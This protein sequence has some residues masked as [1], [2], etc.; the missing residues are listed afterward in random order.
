VSLILCL[1]AIPVNADSNQSNVN[2]FPAQK[3][4]PPV[5]FNPLT[6]SAAELSEY[7]FPARPSDPTELQ[8]WDNVMQYAKHYV[9]PVQYQSKMSWGLKQGGNNYYSDQA[10]YA[11]LSSDN[12]G[13]LT[14]N[15]VYGQWTQNQSSA[16]VGYWVGL[17]GMDNG[18]L[19]QAGGASDL[20]Q[21]VVIQAKLSSNYAFFVEDWPKL[22]IYEATP[23]VQAGNV[24]YVNVVY[25]GA[26]SEAFLLNESTNTYTW[27]NFSTPYYNG[28]SAEYMFEP[29]QYPPPNIGSS[30]FSECWLD[31]ASSGFGLFTDYTYEQYDIMNEAYPG[32]ASNASFTLYCPG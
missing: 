31:N 14:F 11:V 23:V 21:S 22:C 12:G 8:E 27:V 18:Y 24:L 17:G 32:S 6:A 15:E 19:V 1:N 7:G 3:P 26:N 29:K 28:D 20:P 25:N 30:N 9:E 13:H 16:C 2:A 4:G 10:G 5:S